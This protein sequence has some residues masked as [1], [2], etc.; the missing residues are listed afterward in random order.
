MKNKT[1]YTEIPCRRQKNFQKETYFIKY[2]E[3]AIRVE[4]DFRKDRYTR[5]FINGQLRGREKESETKT[6]LRV[7]HEGKIFFLC[8]YYQNRFSFWK[9]KAYSGLGLRINDIPVSKTIA[10][11]KIRQD[12]GH[13]PL[14]FISSIFL[15]KMFVLITAFFAYTQKGLL[16]PQ[17]FL[18][19]VSVIGL[20]F[21]FSALALFYFFTYKK[22][23]RRAIWGGGLIASLQLGQFLAQWAQEA[24]LPLSILF[25]VYFFFLILR[26]LFYA[27]KATLELE[28]P[29]VRSFQESKNQ[30]KNSFGFSFKENQSQTQ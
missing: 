5:V 12:S 1:A 30:E 24:F 27:Y 11:A 29:R 15:G 19:L 3:V 13:L 18:Q 8:Y 21:L 17:S 14:A 4:K 25:I 28:I 10:S 23:Q 9:G 26:S 6:E 7:E 2:Q 22:N 20:Y 16:W